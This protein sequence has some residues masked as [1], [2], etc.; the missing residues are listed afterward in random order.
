MPKTLKTR[1]GRTIIL[2]TPEEDVAITAAA[3]SDPDNPPLAEADFAGMKRG[4]GRPAGSGTKT[5][6]TLRIDSDV[7]EAFKAGGA[8]WQ[9][10]INEALREAIEH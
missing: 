1:S 5:Q 2:P 9:T 6:V 4:P 10:R 3:H 8:G 7:L